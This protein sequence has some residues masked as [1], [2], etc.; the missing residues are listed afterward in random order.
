MSYLIQKSSI[1]TGKN[2]KNNNAM[3]NYSNE[4][5]D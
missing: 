3:N 1:L 4:T 5:M 2:N